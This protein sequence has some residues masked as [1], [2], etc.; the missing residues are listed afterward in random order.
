MRIALGMM[1]IWYAGGPISLPRWKFITVSRP[2]QVSV[3]RKCSDNPSN[4]PRLWYNIR[5]SVL[6]REHHETLTLVLG[7]LHTCERTP[8][9][10][11]A[12][13]WPHLAKMYASKQQ[14]SCSQHRWWHLKSFKTG[15]RTRNRN[16]FTSS[17]V[18]PLLAQTQIWQ[19]HHWNEEPEGVSIFPRY[20]CRLKKASFFCTL[21]VR[22][23]NTKPTLALH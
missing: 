10:Y 14:H 23:P 17:R 7:S 22:P 18:S 12:D 16:L 5:L 15:S 2:R 9:P 6:K 13:T 8:F 1:A 4:G 11:L 3:C 21:S 20:V 19:K